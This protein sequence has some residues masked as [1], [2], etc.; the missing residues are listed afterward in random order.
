MSA[1][2]QDGVSPKAN[3]L[4][5]TLNLPQTAFAMKA[6]LPVNEPLR[7]AQ[8]RQQDLYAQ[9]RASRA[10]RPDTSSTTARPTPTAPSTS[11]TRSTSASRISSSSRRPW[12]ASTHPTSPAGTATACPSRSRSMSSSAARKLEM[13]PIAVRRACREYAAEVP[14]PPARA[15][16]PPRRLRPLA[17]ALLHHVSEYEAAIAETFF[18][19]FETGFVYKGLRPS[20]GAST[21]APPS[22]K[23][24]SSTSSTPARL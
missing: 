1:A 2:S 3:T 14:R 5:S 19:F 10:G 21:T 13:E 24:K 16:H 18:H 11:A 23:P 7:L 6:N 22:P 12:P 9:I 4:K 8:W 17:A 20:P 15:V